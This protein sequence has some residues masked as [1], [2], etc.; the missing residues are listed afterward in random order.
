MILSIIHASRSLRQSHQINVSKDLPFTIVSSDEKILAED[1]PLKLYMKEIQ[2]FVKASD[3]T[4]LDSNVII[5][6]INQTSTSISLVLWHRL[7]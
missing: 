3:I 5:T 2:N 7:L 4:V 6:Y 1:G